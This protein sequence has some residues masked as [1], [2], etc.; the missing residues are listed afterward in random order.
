VE[1]VAEQATGLGAKVAM[2]PRDIPDVGRFCVLQDPQGA[3]I[4]IISYTN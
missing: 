4:S 3:F 1:A 2:P